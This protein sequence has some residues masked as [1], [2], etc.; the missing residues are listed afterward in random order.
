MARIA[1]D[2]PA[3]FS[4]SCIIPVR[5]TDINYGNHAGNDAILS[6]I[7]EARMQFL[8]SYGYTE[9]DL[10]GVGII[11]ADVAIQFKHEAFYGDQLMVSVAVGEITK[12]SFDL[13]YKL[14]TVLPGNKTVLVANAKTGMICYAYTSKKIASLSDEVKKKFTL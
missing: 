8:K 9:L 2:M 13:F 14:E 1:I 7:H 4:F 3:T 5:I 12:I 6:I 10:G 11:M